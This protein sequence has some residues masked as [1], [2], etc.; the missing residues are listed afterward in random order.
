MRPDHNEHA[1]NPIPSEPKAPGWDLFKKTLPALLQRN[2]PTQEL[3]PLLQTLVTHGV[4]MPPFQQQFLEV[5]AASMLM[6]GRDQQTIESIFETIRNGIFSVTKAEN[7]QILPDTTCKVKVER[8]GSLRQYG[9]RTVNNGTPETIYAAHHI[10]FGDGN[11]SDR[12]FYG[13]TEGLPEVFTELCERTDRLFEEYRNGTLDEKLRVIAYFQVWGATI[14]HPF[15]D[16]NG[17]AFNAKLIYDLHRMGMRIQEVPTLG[18]INSLLSENIFTINAGKF[19]ECFTQT[20]GLPAFTAEQVAGIELD[21]RL[22][23]SYNTYLKDRILQGIR[24]GIH[25]EP[26]YEVFLSGMTF[27]LGLVLSREGHIA[28]NFY[29]T[30]APS[31]IAEQKKIEA[32]SR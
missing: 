29:E 12:Y 27:M 23:R 32:Q 4:T 11:G 19:L 20:N 13:L 25:P 28:P 26:R 8:R 21:G 7:G 10:P 17:R 2:M 14:I 22:Q 30:Y 15:V 5:A 16:A 18:E 31:L 3:M 1:F 24:Q 6:R 9:Q